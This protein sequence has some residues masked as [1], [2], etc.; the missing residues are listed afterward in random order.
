MSKRKLTTE[1]NEKREEELM[2][3]LINFPKEIV[4]KGHNRIIQLINDRARSNQTRFE[5]IIKYGHKLRPSDFITII[6]KIGHSRL[7]KDDKKKLTWN[8]YIKRG[9]DS[10]EF[11]KISVL[12]NKTDK[13]YVKIL[14]IFITKNV[15]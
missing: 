7:K 8:Y 6:Q 10:P 3:A 2:K 9:D 5:H 12:E 4:D 13:R 11:I 14:T 15:K 1:Q